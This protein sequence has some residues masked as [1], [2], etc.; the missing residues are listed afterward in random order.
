VGI[1]R[2][3]WHLFLSRGEP[4][5]FPIVPAPSWS[6]VAARAAYN[7]DRYSFLVN[8]RGEVASGWPLLS[9]RSCHAVDPVSGAHIYEPPGMAIPLP[10]HKAPPSWHLARHRELPLIPIWPGFIV[11]SLMYAALAGLTVYVAI[12]LRRYVRRR[13]G[14]CLACGY[15]LG[16]SEVCPECGSSPVVRHSSVA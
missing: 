6:A 1:Q 3:K 2:I 8:V 11:N 10:D 13:R 14:L 5:R 15:P 4:E 9:M 7:D 12:T 16:E